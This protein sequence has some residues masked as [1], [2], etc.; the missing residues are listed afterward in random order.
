MQTRLE[1]TIR[2]MGGETYQPTFYHPSAEL[3]QPRHGSASRIRT[4][5]SMSDIDTTII[6]TFRSTRHH[7][8][9]KLLS[10]P[11]HRQP[12]SG[13]MASLRKRALAATNIP[14]SE[15]STP[16][17]SRDSSPGPSVNIS[18]KELKRLKDGSGKP[19]TSRRRNV[20]IFGLGGLFGTLLAAAFASK[21][22]IV[23]LSALTD[24]NFESLMGVLP[25]GLL[26]EAQALQVGLL[27]TISGVGIADERADSQSYRNTREMRSIT[28][29][30]P[31]VC[32]RGLRASERITLSS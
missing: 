27:S 24:V 25:A 29:P 26:R 5:N 14:D 30:F 20:W 8:L 9:V 12:S 19:K 21:S 13:D 7:I 1:T 31:S 10:P 15:T 32:M 2:L 4:R 17:A 23:D 18:A 6:T 22:D 28:I 3:L 16:S 11:G